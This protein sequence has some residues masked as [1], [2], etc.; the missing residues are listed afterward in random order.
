MGE[1]ARRKRSV[2]V[3][4]RVRVRAIVRVTAQ[5]VPSK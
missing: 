5:E 1:D 3:R 4:V 2:R